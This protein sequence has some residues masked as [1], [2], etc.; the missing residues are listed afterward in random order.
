MA[1]AR[2]VVLQDRDDAGIVIDQEDVQAAWD[3]RIRRSRAF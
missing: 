2:Q 3:G 1:A